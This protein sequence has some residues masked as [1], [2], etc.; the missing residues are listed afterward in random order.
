MIGAE[1][2]GHHR[3]HHQRADLDDVDGD[4]NGRRA[5]Y[6]ATG[7]PGYS[8]GEYHR[9]YRHKDG[10]RIR[11]THEVRP[12]RADQV[13]YQHAHNGHHHSRI[14]PIIQVRAPADDEFRQAGVAPHLI[15]IEER[16]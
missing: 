9:D 13:A 5:V 12:K 1:A 16:L 7:D 11:S 10:T 2:Q 8:E 3:E 15:V 14:N 6:T 4:V